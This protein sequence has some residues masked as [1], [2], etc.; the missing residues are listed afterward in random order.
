M[1]IPD[2]PKYQW[3]QPVWAV[4]DL[5]NDGSFP[6]RGANDVIAQGGERGEIVQVGRHTDS[7]T[8]IYLVEFSGDRVVGCLEPEITA[9]EPAAGPVKE[10][11]SP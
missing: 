11:V 2:P 3:G 9:A 1:N 4:D 5:L 6:G 10:A 7:G 8:I